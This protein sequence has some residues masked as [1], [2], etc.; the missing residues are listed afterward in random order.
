MRDVRLLRRASLRVQTRDV[1]LLRRV[2][3]RALMRDVRLLRHVSLRAPMR[4]VRLLHRTGPLMRGA[5][6]RRRVRL[7]VWPLQ[8][9]GRVGQHRVTELP[10]Q[11]C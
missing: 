4:D 9:R 6:L 1:R 3:L 7:T 10:A 8:V 11:P 5:A 2:N